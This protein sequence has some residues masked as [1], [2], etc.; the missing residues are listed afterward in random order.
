MTPPMV[1]AVAAE[2]LGGA[3]GDDVGAP[4]EGPAQV[5]RGEGVVDHQRD[6]VR[7]GDG[8]HLLERERR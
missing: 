8:G 2:E 6:V 1:G 3:V 7:L 5:G 4:L